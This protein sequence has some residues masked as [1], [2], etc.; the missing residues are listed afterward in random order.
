MPRPA[1]RRR[2]SDDEN[3]QVDPDAE[4]E[5][6]EPVA[7]DDEDEEREKKRQ[8]KVI[9]RRGVALY[10]DVMAAKRS[11]PKGRLA[12]LKGGNTLG[13]W[14]P[15]SRSLP[16]K[17]VKAYHEI[18]HPIK[19]CTTSRGYVRALAKICFDKDVAFPFPGDGYTLSEWIVFLLKWAATL[20]RG[21]RRNLQ[22]REAAL[23][24]RALLEV[25][26]E[27]ARA[28]APAKPGAC[29]LCVAAALKLLK[30]FPGADE[31]DLG[32][33]IKVTRVGAGF[34]LTLHK[35]KALHRDH[36]ELS[37]LFRGWVCVHCNR[38]TLH[39]LDSLS[40]DD[41]KDFGRRVYVNCTTFI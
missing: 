28:L 9:V 27:R 2:K 25:S 8:E 18:G 7:D 36:L 38:Y 10:E 30:R 16:K 29:K 32:G 23:L 13:D 11:S 34:E 21:S 41:Y 6:E 26:G 15:Q 12:F 37:L 17:L 24:T 22:L 39:K 1:K 19:S 20:K 5:E 14:T 3:F 31:I 40:S 4:V 33:Y 35:K